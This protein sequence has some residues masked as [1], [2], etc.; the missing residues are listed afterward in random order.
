LINSS[1]HL[2]FFFFF[3]GAGNLIEKGNIIDTEFF[4]YYFG[5]GQ[6]F[7]IQNDKIHTICQT[8]KCQVYLDWPQ[9]TWSS[10][11]N[12]YKNIRSHIF[13]RVT[14]AKKWQWDKFNFITTRAKK[15]IKKTLILLRRRIDT[16]ILSYRFLFYYF[17]FSLYYLLSERFF[18]PF[19]RRICLKPLLAPRNGHLKQIMGNRCQF[20]VLQPLDWFLN[21]YTFSL[22]S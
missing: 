20:L 12:D 7:T 4:L 16:I 19:S 14:L 21:I 22:F 18:F 6:N 3:L 10:K 11:K 1:F 9:K 2:I 8:K 17:T 15:K 5:H 13:L